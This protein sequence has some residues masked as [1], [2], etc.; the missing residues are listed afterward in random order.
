MDFLNHLPD[1]VSYDTFLVSF[2]MESLYSNIPDDL[3]LEAIKVWLEQR[4]EDLHIRFSKE[5]AVSIRPFSWL[6]PIFFKLY[7]L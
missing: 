3:G 2:G 5:E 1:A 7:I 6:T 4:F